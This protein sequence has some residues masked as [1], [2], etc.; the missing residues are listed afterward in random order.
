MS[1][2][3]GAVLTALMGG[4]S[5][6]TAIRFAILVPSACFAVV[7]VFAITAKRREV[8]AHDAVLAGGH[9]VDDACEYDGCAGSAP[10]R[11]VSQGRTTAHANAWPRRGAVARAPG[12]DLRQPTCISIAALSPISAI[13]A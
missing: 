11:A 13:R 5:D 9:R 3:G 10:R 12:R 4:I 1:I 7:G 8:T 2:I 6:A